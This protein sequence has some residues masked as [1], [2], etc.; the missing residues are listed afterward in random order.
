M[1]EKTYR[2]VLTYFINKII[3]E[4][5]KSNILLELYLEVYLIKIDIF[6]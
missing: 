4:L 2:N 5:L 6:Q 1:L 3:N